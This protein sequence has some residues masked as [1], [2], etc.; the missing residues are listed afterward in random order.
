MRADHERVDESGAIRV[1]PSGL[2]SRRDFADFVGRDVKTISQW[3]WRKTGPVPVN[4]NGRAYYRF[5]EVRR[6]AAGDWQQAIEEQQ[7]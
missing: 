4:V 1:L 5:E 2:I 3:A 7:R 6:F